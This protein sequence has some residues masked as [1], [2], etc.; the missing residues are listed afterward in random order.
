MPLTLTI[1]S[2]PNYA[3][4]YKNKGC[5]AEFNVMLAIFRLI[6]HSIS[7]HL[8]SV[9]LKQLYLTSKMLFNYQFHRLDKVSS[10]CLSISL[11]YRLKDYQKILKIYLAARQSFTKILSNFKRIIWKSNSSQQMIQKAVQYTILFSLKI[12]YKM[13]SLPKIN[14]L[15]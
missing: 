10:I 12:K 5:V 7:D 9:S 6:T 13:K 2:A 4:I 11:N 3:G 14:R 8:E 1:F 15:F